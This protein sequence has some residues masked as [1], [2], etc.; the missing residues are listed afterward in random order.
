MTVTELARGTGPEMGTMRYVVLTDRPA[1]EMFVR[2]AVRGIAEQAPFYSSRLQ[3]MARMTEVPAPVV[4]VDLDPDLD[5]AVQLCC[6]VVEVMAPRQ[7]FGLACCPRRVPLLGLMQLMELGVEGVYSLEIEPSVLAKRIR[8]RTMGEAEV[9]TDFP[10]QG[11]TL[12]LLA[13]RSQWTT[14]H[15]I[16]CLVALGLSDAEIGQRCHLSRHTIHHYIKR[17][18]DLLGTRNRVHLAAWA[19]FNGFYSLHGPDVAACATS[20]S[21]STTT[22]TSPSAT[23]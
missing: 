23:G 6:Q 22:R 14:Y 12:R 7:V 19:G 3:D 21:T 9:F 5:E 4:L 10:I 2:R 13:T 11:D 15:H 18:C 17:L 8:S 1:V 20:T 16:L